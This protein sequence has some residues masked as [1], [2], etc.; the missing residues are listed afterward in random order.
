MS[1]K[2][3]TVVEI[4]SAVAVV[5]SL[6]FVGFEI[7]NSSEQV[8]QNTQALQIAAYQDLIGRIV[9]I[10]TLHIEESTNIESL[11]SLESPTN[12]QAQMLTN[13]LW[14]LF[15]HGDMAY[16]QFE[17]GAISEERMK[18]AMA[19]LVLR[20]QYPQVKA[21]WKQTRTVFVPEYQAYIDNEIEALTGAGK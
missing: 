7:R 9:E 8:E 18:S 15:R 12:D 20:L 13:F 3:S 1:T 19:P 10:N 21:H 16:F 6:I 5:V 14:I 11:V 4:V 17:K 2:T